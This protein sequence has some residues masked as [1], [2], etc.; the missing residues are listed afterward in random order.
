MGLEYKLTKNIK[1]FVLLII[2]KY[3][4]TRKEDNFHMTRLE[5]NKLDSK[6]NNGLLS[7]DDWQLILSKLKK[8]NISTT[9]PKIINK[10]IKPRGISQTIYRD[11]TVYTYYQKFINETISELHKYGNAYV[12]RIYQIEE[13]LRFFPNLEAELQ[14][15]IFY[16]TNSI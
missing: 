14:E 8:D 4:I 5:I 2:K 15:K 12:F 10:P 6:I 11:D 9:A 3:Y 16:L 1:Y 7:N 13:L